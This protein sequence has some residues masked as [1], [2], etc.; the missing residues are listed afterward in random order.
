MAVRAVVTP[1]DYRRM[2]DAQESEKAF[3]ARVLELAAVT[4]WHS[5]HTYDSRRSQAGYPDLTLVRGTRLIFVELKTQR[6][7]MSPAQRAWREVLLA[8]G[9][10]EYYCWRP[11]DWPEIEQVLAPERV[12]RGRAA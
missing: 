1:L 12:R 11:A 3:Q 2:V 7:R 9:K 5:Y 10:V 6:G 8:T 4:G